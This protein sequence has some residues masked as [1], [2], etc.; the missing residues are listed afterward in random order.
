MVSVLLVV[1]MLGVA[2]AVIGLRARYQI[3]LANK[4]KFCEEAKPL[5]K[6]KFIIEYHSR[7]NLS[8]EEAINLLNEYIE[9]EE[10][11]KRLKQKYRITN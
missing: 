6:R 1:F 3:E 4:Q 10:E 5:L 7:Q 8:G 2:C 9:I 11:I